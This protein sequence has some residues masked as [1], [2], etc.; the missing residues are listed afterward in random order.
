MARTRS[1]IEKLE[2]S[3]QPGQRNGPCP[4]CADKP[5]AAFYNVTGVSIGGEP[6]PG[7]GRWTM[8]G[9]VMPRSTT[10]SPFALRAI[11]HRRWVVWREPIDSEANRTARGT[12]QA[13]QFV[14][15]VCRWYSGLLSLSR[16]GCCAR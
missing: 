3:R 12:R 4:V 5:R 8:F 16:E 15:G 1:R 11:R 10:P 2:R 14:C 13:R 7:S 6:D 9:V